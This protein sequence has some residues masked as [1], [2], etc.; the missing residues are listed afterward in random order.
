MIPVSLVEQCLYNG[1]ISDNYRINIRT[2]SNLFT[3]IC[4]CLCASLT[5][6]LYEFICILC[7][8][9]CEGTIFRCVDKINLNAASKCGAKLLQHF[10]KIGKQA[11]KINELGYNVKQG[12]STLSEIRVTL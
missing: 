3:L 10:C 8:L 7:S 2:Y 6:R 1:S 12:G 5:V 11:I 9:T 4:I